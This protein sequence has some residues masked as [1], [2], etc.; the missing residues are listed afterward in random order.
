MPT[1]T[2]GDAISR[3]LALISISVGRD[4]D[5]ACGIV[6]SVPGGPRCNSDRRHAA[7]FKSVATTPLHGTN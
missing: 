2:T 7:C 6:A 5:A 4:N 3:Q 1:L